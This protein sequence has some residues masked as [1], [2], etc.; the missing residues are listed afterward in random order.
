[1][2]FVL[3]YGLS[4]Y[5]VFGN[6]LE[7]DLR[8]RSIVEA[9]CRRSDYLINLAVQS[10]DGKLLA[11]SDRL[12]AI[13]VIEIDSGKEL[14]HSKDASGK[15]FALA[16]ANEGK[17]VAIFGE[18]GLRIS[19]LK[20]DGTMQETNVNGAWIADSLSLHPKEPHLLVQSAAGLTVC[21]SDSGAILKVFNNSRF[22]KKHALSPNGELLA[23]IDAKGAIDVIDYKTEKVL[24]S[25]QA[26]PGRCRQIAFSFTNR[27]LAWVSAEPAVKIYDLATGA[28]IRQIDLPGGSARVAFGPNDRFAMS[29]QSRIRIAE[30]PKGVLL[31][32]IN[33]QPKVIEHLAFG[34]KG[35][36][37]SVASHSVRGW[38]LP[39][40]FEL[41]TDDV[42]HAKPGDRVLLARE[43]WGAERIGAPQSLAFSRDG[44]TLFIGDMGGRIHARS[45]AL[46]RLQW[47]ANEAKG[48]I[49]TIAT[50]PD[51]Q[52][53][54]SGSEQGFV[55]G[56]SAIDGTSLFSQKAHTKEVC[57]LR[58]ES[59]GNG[60]G[61]GIDFASASSDE[62]AQ[63]RYAKGVAKVSQTIGNAKGEF[64]APLRFLGDL[65]HELN[66]IGATRFPQRD[67]RVYS[68]PSLKEKYKQVTAEVAPALR[69]QFSPCGRWS[70]GQSLD[71]S[72]AFLVLDAMTG[73]ESTRIECSAVMSSAAFSSKGDFLALGSWLDGGRIEVWNIPSGIKALTLHGLPSRIG[74]VAFAPNDRYLAAIVPQGI[75]VW[76][77]ENV[78]QSKKLPAPD[79][80]SDRK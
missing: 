20:S 32:A 52:T 31:E 14:Y 48:P 28:L 16:L 10:P 45:A 44:K 65:S 1:M 39:R 43:L 74:G 71:G 47:T 8:L 64:R 12:G 21:D 3:A 33:G 79:D 80:A 76:Q 7:P 75:R 23:I 59:T 69:V 37:S 17:R 18:R 67:A 4:A 61:F 9:Y 19:N 6:E 54:I 2:W 36:L 56:W 40:K 13:S 78:A 38:S 60:I 58:W 42:K 66:Q 68:L 27:T 73:R 57:A 34:E 50:S 63:W 30:S 22:A 11:V 29:N 25:L 77:I 41:L 5:L 15:L 70:V 55:S 53:I 72:K 51:G 49:L 24:H 46:G 26:G 62:I 35:S